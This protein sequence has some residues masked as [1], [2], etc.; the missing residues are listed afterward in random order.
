MTSKSNTEKLVLIFFTNLNFFVRKIA[1]ATHRKELSLRW[2]DKREI[3]F[4]RNLALN[5]A[6]SND[7]SLI[8]ERIIFSKLFLSPGGTVLELGFGDGLAG[9]LIYSNGQ[10][11]YVGID[12]SPDALKFAKR[13]YQKPNVFF[14]SGDILE[15]F[16]SGN[17]T[18]VIWDGGIGFFSPSEQS[19]ILNSVARCLENPVSNFHGVLSGFTISKGILTYQT[20]TNAPSSKSELHQILQKYFSNVVVV[21]RLHEK[22]TYFYFAASNNVNS[23]LSPKLSFFPDTGIKNV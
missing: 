12:N 19:K 7:T 13:N 15:D 22:D 18:N 1:Q 16:P 21:E 20:Y 14:E 4:D 10:A 2:A 5:T 23:A 6:H 11:S 8:F 9:S 17:F 3:F